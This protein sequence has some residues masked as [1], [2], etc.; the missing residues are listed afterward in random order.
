[1]H[2]Y[3]LH[4]VGITELMPVFMDQFYQVSREFH[5]TS[6]DRED[7][8][9]WVIREAV[10]KYLKRKYMTGVVGHYRCDIGKLVYDHV[11]HLVLTSINPKLDQIF[12]EPIIHYKVK[13]MVINDVIV[14]GK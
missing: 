11:E 10:D 6:Y 1:M 13:V 12:K 14:I 7:V 3:S 2:F 9:D 8:Y 4:L 5:I